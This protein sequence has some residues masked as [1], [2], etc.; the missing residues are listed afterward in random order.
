MDRGNVDP[1]SVIMRKC[2]F[3]SQILCILYI[4]TNGIKNAG[5]LCP[6][7]LSSALS[8]ALDLCIPSV[9]A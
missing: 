8:T 6:R 9:P 3:L 2:I 5:K 1:I 4:Y 7:A